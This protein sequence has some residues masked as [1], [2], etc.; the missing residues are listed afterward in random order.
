MRVDTWARRSQQPLEN[1]ITPHDSHHLYLRSAAP[2]G[3]PPPHPTPPSPPAHGNG[4]VAPTGDTHF[5]GNFARDWFPPEIQAPI[6]RTTPIMVLGITVSSCQ[7]MFYRSH[8]TIKIQLISCDKF[9]CSTWPLSKLCFRPRGEL[10]DHLGTIFEYL[11]H[12]MLVGANTW[13]VYNMD[14]IE[15]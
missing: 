6:G 15:S 8:S 13:F 4:I 2:A 9:P 11:L 7:Q 1:V 12:S 3:S 10:W 14:F 5:I